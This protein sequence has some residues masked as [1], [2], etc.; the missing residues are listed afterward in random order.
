[1]PWSPPSRARS[2][3]GVGRRSSSRGRG[4]ARG[5]R[6][7]PVARGVGTAGVRSGRRTRPRRSPSPVS[8][9]TAAAPRACARSSA[10]S[11]SPSRHAAA[12]TV[13]GPRQASPRGR[14]FGAR[15]CAT[16]A[17]GRCTALGRMAPRR[18][19]SR[20]GTAAPSPARRRH[21]RSVQPEG[22]SAVTALGR[23]LRLPPRATRPGAGGLPVGRDPERRRFGRSAVRGQA[24]A[25][26]DRGGSPSVTADTDGLAGF[27]ISTRRRGGRAAGRGRADAPARDGGSGDRRG[28]AVGVPRSAAGSRGGSPGPG[29]RSDRAGTRRTARRTRRAGPRPARIA[30][31]SGKARPVAVDRPPSTRSVRAARRGGPPHD[32]ARAVR[33]A[34][35]V[36]RD[37]ARRSRPILSPTLP[38][39]RGRGRGRRSGRRR[40]RLHDDAGRSRLPPDAELG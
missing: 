9:G 4:V 34:A 17:P 19:A 1:M 40:R 5:S 29:C 14:R 2:D 6:P 13:R 38:G 16:S 26:S 22:S 23:S 3:P 15:P 12:P 7:P 24:D 25:P 33:A 35:A 39:P 27:A 10:A 30:G 31:E 36:P 8:G 28:P 11:A 21:A 20:V 32:A 37:A 18:A